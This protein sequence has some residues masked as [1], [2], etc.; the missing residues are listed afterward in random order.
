GVWQSGGLANKAFAAM[1][2]AQNPHGGQ[3]T[4]LQTL[5]ITAMHWSAILV[6]LGYTSPAVFASGG[7]PYGVSVTATGEGLTD[8]DTAAIEHQATR[9]VEIAA[10]LA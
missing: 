4:T 10:K 1:T 9:L 2:S 6:P 5:Y 8:E 7:N 3:E